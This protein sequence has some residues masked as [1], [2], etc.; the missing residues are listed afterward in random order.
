M[1]VT[2]ALKSSQ[3]LSYLLTQSSAYLWLKFTVAMR[4]DQLL[5]LYCVKPMQGVHELRQQTFEPLL[6]KLAHE[7]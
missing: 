1:S 6:K 4:D 2:F 3:C 5:P 7:I